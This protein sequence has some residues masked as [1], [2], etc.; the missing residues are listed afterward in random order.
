MVV[1]NVNCECADWQ[2][3]TSG[4]YS[5]WEVLKDEFVCVCVYRVRGHRCLKT[6]RTCFVMHF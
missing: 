1:G 2:S 6:S 5:Q 4:G 3:V